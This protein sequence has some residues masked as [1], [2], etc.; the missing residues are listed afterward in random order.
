MNEKGLNYA[1]AIALHDRLEA[2]AIRY[3]A[4]IPAGHRLAIKSPG[5]N[6]LSL[7]CQLQTMAQR[8]S[9]IA[10]APPLFV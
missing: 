2:M 5:G 6:L 8:P 1:V 9:P 3:I 7:L 4:V 10:P